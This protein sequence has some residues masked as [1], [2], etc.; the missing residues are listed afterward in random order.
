MTAVPCPLRIRHG[1]DPA[2]DLPHPRNWRRSELG[3]L[4]ETYP[5]GGAKAVH[6]LL[7]HRSISTIY[8]I[9]NRRGLHSPRQSR[10]EASHGQ[11]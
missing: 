1:F 10:K 8:V 4:D 2:E 5:R 6:R 7:P 9:A 3:I 11:A